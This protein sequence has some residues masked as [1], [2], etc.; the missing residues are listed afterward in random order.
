MIG[1]MRGMKRCSYQS[2]PRRLRPIRRVRKPAVERDAEEDQHRARDLPD[3]RLEAL[4]VETEPAREHGQVEV[5][6]QR[7]GDDLE[8]RVEDDEH[9]RSLAVAPGDVVPDQHHRD[10]AREPDDDHAGAVGGLVG[11]QQ[12]GE[13]EHERRPDDPGEKERDAEEAAIADAVVAHPAEVLVAHLREHR[14]HHQEQ[15]GGDRQR[16]RADLQLAEPVVQARQERAESQPGGHRQPDP[17]RQEAVERRE[18]AQHGRFASQPSRRGG[19]AAS[20]TSRLLLVELR[21][22]LLDAG[23][24]LVSD[25]ANLVRSACLPDPR[26]PSRCSAC[27]G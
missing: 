25:L 10:A 1:A 21:E 15:S 27:P 5:A 20:T 13:R 17:E 3:A 4:R 2:R 8:E 23:G 6:E 24:D 7:V 14:V 16:D 18:L 19:F 9:R 11:E 22:Q 12:P 26:A